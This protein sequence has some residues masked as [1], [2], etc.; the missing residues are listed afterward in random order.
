[1][2][3]ILSHLTLEVLVCELVLTPILNAAANGINPFS[4]KLIKGLS[5]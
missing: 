3:L 1:M 4:D 2:I 5:L